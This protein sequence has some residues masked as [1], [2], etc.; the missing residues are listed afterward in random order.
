MNKPVVVDL[1]AGAG[2]EG[3]GL[4]QVTLKPDKEEKYDCT[5]LCKHV[6]KIEVT[7]YRNC[8]DRKKYTH[9]QLSNNSR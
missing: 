8:Q 1:F 2:G 7:K 6:D 4:L 3:V 9:A 5:K